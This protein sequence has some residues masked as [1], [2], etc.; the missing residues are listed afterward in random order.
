MAAE[1]PSIK[2]EDKH[3]N[4]KNIS[5][6]LDRLTLLKKVEPLLFTTDGMR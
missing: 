1:H 5:E 4:A 2:D 3:F 6:L